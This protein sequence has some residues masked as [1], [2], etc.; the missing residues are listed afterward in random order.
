MKK[1]LHD[2]V[3][4]NLLAAGFIEVA[5][6]TAKVCFFR[7]GEQ[8]LGRQRSSNC[9]D[10]A[11]KEER[12]SYKRRCFEKSYTAYKRAASD[13]STRRK[14]Q[15]RKANGECLS[16]FLLTFQKYP[17]RWTFLEFSQNFVNALT[18]KAATKQTPSIWGLLHAQLFPCSTKTAHVL[19][20]LLL[21]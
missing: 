19:V 18:L 21:A 4:G 11:S 2:E 10:S 14:T 20:V 15:R 1:A 9:K 13:L 7:G 12:S 6:L 5:V 3:Q 8:Q 17:R 16:V